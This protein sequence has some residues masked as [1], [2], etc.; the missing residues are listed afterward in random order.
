MW[1][2]DSQSVSHTDALGAAMSRVLPPRLVIGLCGPLGAGKTQFVRSL[3]AACGV[4][5]AAIVSPTFV[6]CQEYQG[7]T[8]IYHF[9]AYRLA[10]EDEFLA[11]GVDEC[12]EADAIS[13]VEWADRVEGCLP[14]DRLMV[15]LEP[16]GER[17]RQFTFVATGANAGKFLQAVRQE[18]QS[19]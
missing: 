4:P 13:I 5:P 6:L 19:V 7:R 16:T 3:A 9:D 12:F 14:D 1:Q 11:L 8:L 2:F 17:S 15:L 10:D 18:V